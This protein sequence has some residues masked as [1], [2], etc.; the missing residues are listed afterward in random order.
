MV[1]AIQCA[2]SDMTGQCAQCVN[3]ETLPTDFP[4]TITQLFASG[5]AFAVPGS[6]QFCQ[7]VND[8]ICQ[9]YSTQYGCCE[10]ACGS[11]MGAFRTCVF[12]QVAPANI[13]LPTPCTDTCGKAAEP[14]GGGTSTGLIAACATVGVLVLLVLLLFWYCR[15]KRRLAAAGDGAT[16]LAAKGDDEEAP[17][18]DESEDD[19]DDS[20]DDEEQGRGG[21]KVAQKRDVTGSTNGSGDTSES[22]DSQQGPSQ[23]EIQLA[24]EKRMH[25]LRQQQQMQALEQQR[26]QQ[27]HLLRLRQQEQLKLQHQQEQREAAT[28]GG[29]MAMGMALTAGSQQRSKTTS[30][31]SDSDSQSER[32]IEKA[33]LAGGPSVAREKKHAIEEWQ[34]AKRRGSKQD[35]KDFEENRSAHSTR[36]SSRVKSSKS[37]KS[38]SDHKP[39]RISSRDLSQIIKERSEKALRVNELEDEKAEM[40]DSLAKAKREAESLRHERELAARRIAEL[41][42]QNRKLKADMRASGSGSRP[43]SSS[44]DLS[45]SR[46]GP[47]SHHRRRSKS[48]E[49]SGHSSRSLRGSTKVEELTTLWNPEDLKHMHS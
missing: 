6:D 29:D 27:E 47:S 43:S 33:P 8:R 17:S 45:G 44:R 34:Q 49:G 38:A 37:I 36:S 16:G 39:K 32:S 18:L 13:G 41:E 1:A 4:E 40:E 20:V 15:R 25:E 23:R 46:H 24:Q 10:D 22:E 42:A 9:D 11:Q 3:I 35:L 28:P 31:T 5:Q 26:L 30:S 14:S 12:E 21:K 7:V 19:D 2:A 48:R